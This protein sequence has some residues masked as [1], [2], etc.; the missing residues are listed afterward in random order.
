MTIVAQSFDV[1]GVDD[2]VDNSDASSA[3]SALFAQDASIHHFV[4]CG[5]SGG[6]H[7]D[8]TRAIEI[9]Q[10]QLKCY[11]CGKNDRGSYRIPL[12]C[13]AN[14]KEEFDQLKKHH[15]N[16]DQCC[17]AAHVGCSIWGR[18]DEGEYLADCRRV[19]FFPGKDPRL[20]RFTGNQED[21]RSDPVACMYC[22]LHASDLKRSVPL[23]TV[24]RYPGQTSSGHG[25][26]ISTTQKK[27]YPLD[28]SHV[29][30]KRK[31]R[32]DGSL[33]S[34]RTSTASKPTSKAKQGPN[35]DVPFVQ[36]PVAKRFGGKFRADIVQHAR[37]VDAFDKEAFGAVLKS[38]RKFWKQKLIQKGLTTA[39]FRE[40]WS[41]YTDNVVQDVQVK[42]MFLEIE[43]A[44]DQQKEQGRNLNDVLLAKKAK[45]EALIDAPSFSSMWSKVAHLVSADLTVENILADIRHAV[46]EG[47]A[48]MEEIL[49]TQKNS[50]AGKLGE[51]IDLDELWDKV[52]KR[53]ESEM[54]YDFKGLE[55][56]ADESC[57]KS[58]YIFLDL[59]RWDTSET[60]SL[61]LAPPEYRSSPTIEELLSDG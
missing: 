54:N 35:D 24:L 14:D 46:S 9:Q 30:R 11:I 33:A 4:F 32:D 49:E 42:Q 25:T 28:V 19:Y 15:N 34:R 38:R 29:S 43:S 31:A 26:F 61:G 41:N 20:Y 47:D 59:S 2:S 60:L 50:W 5:K 10:T 36:T 18:N 44:R 21:L 17:M 57:D 8:W 1:V 52:N 7:T 13:C 23:A 12:Q 51:K 37:V 16:L 55:W 58:K 56:S 45:F 22:G 39:N 40:L 53:V 6:E 3:N 27:R 48:H